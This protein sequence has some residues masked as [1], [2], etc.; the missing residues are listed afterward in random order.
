M[1]YL[2]TKEDLLRFTKLFWLPDLG[3]KNSMT[4]YASFMDSDQ[5]LSTKYGEFPL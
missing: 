2:Q 3:L 1:S 4:I 5:F